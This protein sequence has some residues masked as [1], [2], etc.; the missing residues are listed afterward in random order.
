ML[1]GA[2]LLAVAVLGA[3]PQTA[4]V[5][6]KATSVPTPDVARVA[7]AIAGALNAGGVKVMPRADAD[8]KLAAAGVAPTIECAG[9]SACLG[10]VAAAL[11]LRGVVGVFVTEVV[12]ERT[13]FL[14][15]VKRGEDRSTLKRDFLVVSGEKIGRA[16]LGD[17]VDASRAL[18]APP[19]VVLTHAPPRDHTVPSIIGGS[20]G[21]V[22]IA[23]ITVGILGV[24]A[25][26]RFD[27]MQRHSQDYLRADVEAAA[28]QANTLPGVGIALAV[29]GALLG[30][31][32]AVLW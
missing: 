23:G 3:E 31:T 18:L 21:A 29:A 30:A 10:Q 16:E 14:S 26:G 4:V 15:L 6:T 20:G 1:L 11:D 28:T 19:E 24:T 7:D 27:D 22:L 12:G 2:A 17:F 8:A 13:A 32:A 5:L 9:R 25:K